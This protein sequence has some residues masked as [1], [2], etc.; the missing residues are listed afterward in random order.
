MTTKTS[1]PNAMEHRRLCEFNVPPSRYA[2]NTIR[3][4]KRLTVRGGNEVLREVKRE[5]AAPLLHA[6]PIPRRTC[7]AP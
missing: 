3:A 2:E 6:H 1:V 4:I 5:K 7:I